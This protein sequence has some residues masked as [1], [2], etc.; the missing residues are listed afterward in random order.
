[1]ANVTASVAYAEVTGA[2]YTRTRISVRLDGASAATLKGIVAA[3]VD[4]GTIPANAHA[5]TKK[6][7]VALLGAVAAG[8]PE[9]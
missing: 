8:T 7:L 1:M 6:A 2:P 3:L 9:E 4:A 5:K